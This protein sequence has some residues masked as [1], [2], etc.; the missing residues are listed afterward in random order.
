MRIPDTDGSGYKERGNDRG[1]RGDR[2]SREGKSRERIVRAALQAMDHSGGISDIALPMRNA[3]RLV[4]EAVLDRCEQYRR[5]HS[6]DV[7]RHP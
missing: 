2:D 3:E 1:N 7:Y 6:I 4:I 5:E